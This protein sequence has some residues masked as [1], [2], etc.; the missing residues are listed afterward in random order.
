MEDPVCKTM[1]ELVASFVDTFVDFSV[2]GIF[3]PPSNPNLTPNSASQVSFPTDPSPAPQPLQTRYPAPDRLIAIGDLHGDLE[4]SKQAFRLA[5]LIDGSD[6]WTG[7]SAA[8]V[9]VGDVFDRGG[10]ELKI[11]YF[12]EKLKREAV[13]SGGYLITINGNHEIRNVEGNFGYA[14]KAGLEEFRAWGFWFLAGNQIKDLC[15]GL[16][17][18]KDPF[19]G[20]PSVIPGVKEEYQHGFRARIAALRPDGPIARRFLSKNLTVA[21]VGDSVFVHGGV[22]A[23][24]VN[25]GLERINEEV[26]NW[27]NG[28]MG[29]SDPAHCKGRNA[30]IRS[31][32]FSDDSK[33]SCD[34]SALEHVLATIPGA[35]RMI[36]GHTIQKFGI[37]GVCDN[38]AIR[39]DVGMS[40]GCTN[41]LPEVLEING[42][43]E[44]QVLTSNPLY[45]NKSKS[46]LGADRKQ[47]SNTYLGADRKQEPGVLLPEHKEVAVEA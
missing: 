5:G 17:K 3:L 45:Q 19:Q 1:P 22:L 4:K 25:Y 38:R 11:L 42:N 14:T 44:L 33:T 36:M 37:N 30:V 41:G 18:Q 28:L 47:G 27:L 15:R 23:D 9:Q 20:I 32:K 46:Y 43:S 2:G 40:K 10:E 13:R 39:I 31:R 24:H 7:G 6:R 21:V 34:C 26:S 8:V 12:L 16:E 35:K 29:K